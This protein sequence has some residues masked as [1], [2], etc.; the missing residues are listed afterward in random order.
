[1]AGS[2]DALSLLRLIESRPCLVPTGAH[3]VFTRVHHVPTTACRPRARNIQP[4]TRYIVPAPR[5][6][7]ATSPHA[8][9]R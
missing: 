2:P 6:Y 7:L 8:K 9:L 5:T 3:C 4:R 1:M